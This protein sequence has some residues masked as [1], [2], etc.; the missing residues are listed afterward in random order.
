M[1]PTMTDPPPQL[2]VAED[3][4]PREQSS[5]ASSQVD[6]R[7][8][9]EKLI[10]P[11]QQQSL[12]S[13][14]LENAATP[15]ATSIHADA[16]STIYYYPAPDMA[17]H[18]LSDNLAL[19]YTNIYPNQLLPHPQ[20]PLVPPQHLQQVQQQQQPQ[21]QPSSTALNSHP[22]SRPHHRKSNSLTQSHHGPVDP[23]TLRVPRV[24]VGNLAFSVGWQD[25][26]DFFRNALGA[27]G[28]VDLI[29]HPSGRSKGCAVVEFDSIEE[30][31]RAINELNNA[32]IHGRKIFIRED[33]EGK[34]FGAQSAQR[35]AAAAQANVM[36][37]AAVAPG[38]SAS[39]GVGGVMYGGGVGGMMPN[40]GDV[41]GPMYGAGAPGGYGINMQLYMQYFQELQQ[42]QMRQQQ[43]QQHQQQQ[44]MEPF[45][46]GQPQP[47]SPLPLPLQSLSAGFA[48]QTL[49]LPF[50]PPQ[51]FMSHPV[52]SAYTPN[53]PFIYPP[54]SPTSNSTPSTSPPPLMSP[55]S[56]TSTTY[57]P[58][59]PH[60]PT[61][62]DPHS[63]RLLLSNLP[64]SFTRSQL[65][66]LAATYSVVPQRCEIVLDSGTGRSRG[67]GVVVYGSREEC[68]R[69]VDEMRGL[70]VGERKIHVR[71]DEYSG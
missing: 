41:Y 58:P 5:T 2:S 21:L 28:R 8:V 55:S 60:H 67:V 43:Q 15:L 34:G 40:G 6:S 71:R 24:Y 20:Y 47:S 66:E 59:L 52:L 51:P 69:V 33:R 18:P 10:A 11:T 62:T 39:P 63:P 29:A 50:T 70:V 13:L 12:P 25:L 38:A 17:L 42:H 61:A 19:Q 27:V 68:E 30:A 49:S 54:L 32:E 1:G 53:R 31:G 37:G 16:S 7:S 4:S 46:P 35:A 3:D 9:D 14:S 36:A 23:T 57:P 22:T 45:L 56:T 65:Y 48:A 44:Q 64:F 26:K